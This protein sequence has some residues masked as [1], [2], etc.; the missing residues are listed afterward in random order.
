MPNKFHNKIEETVESGHSLYI[1]FGSIFV[2]P[3][4][5]KSHFLSIPS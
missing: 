5:K 2:G 3:R 4:Q 1:Y